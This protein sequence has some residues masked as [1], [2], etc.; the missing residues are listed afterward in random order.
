MNFYSKILISFIGIVSIFLS[1]PKID[2]LDY[3]KA[4]N[5]YAINRYLASKNLSKGFG[6]Y[7]IAAANSVPNVIRIAPVEF[8]QKR[9]KAAH[10]LT[11]PEWYADGGRF[12]L[13]NTEEEALKLEKAY[14]PADV[15]KI[16][17]VFVTIWDHNITIPNE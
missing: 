8:S 9:L 6:L 10:T 15:T 16:D 12:V 13:C 14:G 7:W 11:K 2:T 3:A 1:Y 4:N 17:N 5:N